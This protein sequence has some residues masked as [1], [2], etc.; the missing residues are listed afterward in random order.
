M[1]AANCFPQC[2]LSKLQLSNSFKVIFNNYLADN[3]VRVHRD[4]HQNFAI[5][6]QHFK[7]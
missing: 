6:N 4:F 2:A 3:I 5:E 1:N 7:K